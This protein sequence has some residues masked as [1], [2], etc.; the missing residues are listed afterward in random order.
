M[1]LIWLERTL[2]QHTAA[3]LSQHM[4]AP[5]AVAMLRS[6]SGKSSKNGEKYAGTR[7][8]VATAGN[9][10]SVEEKSPKRH[11]EEAVS[12]TKED[13]KHVSTRILILL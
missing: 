8:E 7:R 5:Y 12:F 1:P 11:E 10:I 13:A 2:A 4:L 6:L 3:M 9:C